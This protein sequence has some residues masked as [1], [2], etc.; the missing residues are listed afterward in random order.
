MLEHELTHRHYDG[1]VR[2]DLAVKFMRARGFL[3][4]RCIKYDRDQDCFYARQDL[5]LDI[6]DVCF[7][8]LA[9]LVLNSQASKIPVYDYDYVSLPGM[10]ENMCCSGSNEKN[11]AC[12][13]ESYTA[14]RCCVD[15]YLVRIGVILETFARETRM[16]IEADAMFQQNYGEHFMDRFR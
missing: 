7:F 1:A 11:P 8:P 9:E 14:D 12:F 10:M 4:E 6:S 15:R 13:D 5:R 2:K 16:R 3:L